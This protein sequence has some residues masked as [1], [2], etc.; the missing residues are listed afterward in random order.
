MRHE[1][2]LCDHSIVVDVEYLEQ[3]FTQDPRQIAVLDE[4][5]LVESFLL[6]VLLAIRHEASQREVFIEVTQVGQER[7]VQELA[8]KDL[9]IVLY[10]D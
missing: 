7:F 8:I 10:Q 1:C 4:S 5:H 2:I 3:A 9:I 6:E